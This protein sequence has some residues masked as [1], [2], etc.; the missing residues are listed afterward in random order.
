[1]APEKNHGLGSGRFI[2]SPSDWWS[3]PGS[4]NNWPM[5]A[6]RFMELEWE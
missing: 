4:L 5:E 6:A 1:M 3:H 2:P